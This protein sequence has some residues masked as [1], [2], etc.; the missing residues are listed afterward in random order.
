MALLIRASL[1]RPDEIAYFLTL[2][3]AGTPLDT[4]VGIAGTRWTIESCL[5]A[6]KGEVGLD[7]YEVR[8]WTGWH[9]HITAR[10]AGTRLSCRRATARHRGRGRRNTRRRAA[11][12]DRAR[13]PAAALRTRLG[14]AAQPREDPRLVRL[15]TRSSAMRQTMS[16]ERRG[17]TL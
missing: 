12:L 3:P 15:A 4:L 16:L 6:A 7:D 14:P 9:R 11:A 17:Q 10:H 5:E 2:A 8:S 13:D 1:E